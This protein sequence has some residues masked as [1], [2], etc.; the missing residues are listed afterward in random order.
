MTLSGLFHSNFRN[1]K[2]LP[3]TSTAIKL[4]PHWYLA[5][6]NGWSNADVLCPDWWVQ[7]MID[8][9]VPVCVS[10]KRLNKKKTMVNRATHLNTWYVKFLL[11]PA[12]QLQSQFLWNVNITLLWKSI[13]IHSGS[14]SLQMLSLVLNV[15]QFIMKR[16]YRLSFF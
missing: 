7:L 11:N 8:N 13:F 5:T 4:Y 16:Q 14:L 9:G 3:D 1:K 15:N 10:S 12:P 2:A 6:P